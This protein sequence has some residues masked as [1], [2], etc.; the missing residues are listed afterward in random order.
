ME[1][2]LANIRQK[3]AA[4]SALNSYQKKKYVWKMCYI[5]MLGYDIDFGHIEVISLLSSS[6]FQEKSVGYMGVS[7]LLKPGDEMINLMVASVK[8]DLIGPYHYGQTLALAAVGNFG[9][10]DFTEALAVEVQRMLANP[11]ESSRS[12]FAPSSLEEENKLRALLRKKAALCLLRLYRSN[13]ACLSVP[14]W[15]ENLATILVD[16]D[17]GVLISTMSLVLGLC[18]PNAGEFEP[19][20]PYVIDILNRIVIRKDC[21]P[22]YLYYGTPS[23]WLQVRCLKFLQFFPMPGGEERDKISRALGAILQKMESADNN[24]TKNGDY[25]ILFEAVNLIIFYGGDIES[26]LHQSAVAYLAKFIA[27]QDANIR[28][29]GLDAMYKLARAEGPTEVQ[30]HQSVVVTSIKDVDNSVQKRALDLLFVMTDRSNAEDIVNELLLNLSSS[31]AIIKQDITVKIAILSEKFAADLKWYL[32][33]LVKVIMVAGDFVSEDVWH[34]VVHIVTNNTELHDYAAQKLYEIVQ[35]KFAH[36]IVIALGAY[37]LGEFGVNICEKSGSSGYEQFLALQSHF[38]AMSLR[39]KAIMLT[40]YMKFFNLYPDVR[41]AITEVFRKYSV[42]GH[43]ELQQRAC[44]YL[45]MP[46][47]GAERMESVWNTMP[48]YPEN[49]ESALVRSLEAKPETEAALS[50]PKPK[51][52]INQSETVVAPKAAPQ[53]VDLLSLDEVVSAPPASGAVSG[54]PA[55]ALPKLR[56]W[57]NAVP[58][59]VG[60]PAV[61]YEDSLVRLTVQWQYSAH[62]GRLMIIVNNLS[63][64]DLSDVRFNIPEVDYLKIAVTQDI[65]SKINFG[66]QSRYLLA[67][68]CLKPFSDAPEINLYFRTRQGAFAYPLRLPI[69]AACFFE[70]VVLDKANYMTRWK[71]LEGEDREVQEVFQSSKPVTPQLMAFIREGCANALKFGPAQGLDTE[72]TFTGCATFRTGTLAPDGSG[73]ISVGGMLRLEADAAQGRM[74]ITARAKHGKVAL[75]MKNVIKAQLI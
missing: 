9:G 47:I 20:V 67:V 71:A 45:R 18:V 55:D 27:Q 14:E 36:E 12:G 21:T 37:V 30:P 53:V 49:R 51:A 46:S 40:T 69:T 38:P 16:R 66:E 7:L 32:D 28:Y 68:E 54:I 31:D 61:L 1:K 29:L 26:R 57:F 13:P 24:A 72:L 6:K 25:A 11:H 39:T 60:K 63:N 22:D 59:A 5:F 50:A 62:Q 74:R 4:S 56:T 48:A 3:F 8:N 52:V 43:L 65:G 58:F 23:P 73:M 34:R 75:A 44:E 19:L 33:T 15:V 70:P 64:E 42:S 17:L 2:E 35:S 41:P 10:V